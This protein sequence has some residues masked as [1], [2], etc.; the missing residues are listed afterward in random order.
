M[1]IIREIDNF[2]PITIILET[3]TEAINLRTVVLRY[4]NNRCIDSN[5]TLNIADKLLN[6]LTRM[7]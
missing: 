5:S 6:E 4:V 3:Y 1:K 2:R 7:T